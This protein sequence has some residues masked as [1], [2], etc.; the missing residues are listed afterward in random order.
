VHGDRACTV[1]RSPRVVSAC[2]LLLLL[3]WRRIAMGPRSTAL[4]WGTTFCAL[5]C[6]CA[7]APVKTCTL[8]C[9]DAKATGPFSTALGF[10]TSASGLHSTALGDS[11]AASGKSSTALGH[12][13]SASQYSTSMGCEL[14]LTQTSQ[15]PPTRR[16]WLELN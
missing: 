1:T 6:A 13:T 8:S 5:F 14:Q 7:Q 11:C 3:S 12:H 16:F 4:V 2:P 10:N 15:L 9:E